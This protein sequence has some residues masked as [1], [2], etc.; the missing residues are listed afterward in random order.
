MIKSMEKL[1]DYREL[2][3]AFTW[4]NIRVKY[5]QTFMGIL[6]ALF[7][8]VII[9]ISGVVVKSAIA[10]LNGRELE[11]EGFATVTVKSL[12]W[13]FFVGAVKFSVGSLTA[14][15][16]LVNKVYFP[17]VIFPLAYIFSQLFDFL[18]AAS[19]FTLVLVYVQIGISVHILWLPLLILFL[20]LF[21]AG[22]SML[23]ACG[24]LFYRDVK[25]IVDVLIM[26]AIFFT[27]VFYDVSMFPDKALFLMLNPMGSILELINAVVVLHQAPHFG[28]FLYIGLW[29]VGLF[30][31]GWFAFYKM[32]PLFADNI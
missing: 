12:P 16:N 27:P 4:R 32:E 31:S 14:N 19:A 25:Y 15:L 9:L 13:A 17:R 3:W 5:K 22:L 18:I 29:S 28:W 2:L 6:W 21:T 10:T 8:P 23:L 11:L 30:L 7:M 1:M 24:N 26:F 20:I